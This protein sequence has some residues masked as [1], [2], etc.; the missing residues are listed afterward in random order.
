M[1]SIFTSSVGSPSFPLP[2]SPSLPLSL[3]LSYLCLHP[4]IITHSTSIID[5]PSL[6]THDLLQ[7]QDSIV[8]FEVRS[9]FPPEFSSHGE[10]DVA[11][12]AARRSLTKIRCVCVC[13]ACVY[14]CASAQDHTL[15][16]MLTAQ[17]LRDPRVL[18]AGYKVPHPLENNFVL[19]IQVREGTVSCQPPRST[20]W[21]TQQ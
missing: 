10:H 8:L 3:P 5:Q 2:P 13:V 6:F 15:G 17:L 14:V 12:R 19:K 21:S 4:G 7:R 11:V 1:G 18:F 20:L 9:H 16:G